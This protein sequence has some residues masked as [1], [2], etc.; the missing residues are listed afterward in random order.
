MVMLGACTFHQERPTGI[1]DQMPYNT[2]QAYVCGWVCSISNVY[3]SLCVLDIGGLWHRRIGGGYL[4]PGRG[5][6]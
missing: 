3:T 6:P 5:G 2:A 4:G 1:I